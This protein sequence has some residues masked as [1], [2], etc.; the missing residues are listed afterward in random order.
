ML[1]GGLGLNPGSTPGYTNG[2]AAPFG[3]PTAQN[4]GP[5]MQRGVGVLSLVGD[6]DNPDSETT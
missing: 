4:G 6:C 1:D 5:E 3:T 2:A